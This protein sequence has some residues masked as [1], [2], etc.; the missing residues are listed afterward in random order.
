MSMFKFRNIAAFFLAFALLSG[1]ALARF[2]QPD[3]IG[4]EGGMNLYA[5]VDGNPISFSDPD[6]LQRRPGG[7]PRIR[8][9]GLLE[10]YYVPLRSEPPPPSAPV[11]R[12][13]SQMEL[14][15]GRPPQNSPAN[16]CGRDFSGHAFDR[17]QGRGLTPSVVIDAINT[18]VRFPGGEPGT[19]QYYSP[20]NNVSVVINSSTGAVVSVRQG[21]PSG[22]GG[23]R[24]E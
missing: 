10:Q 13:G 5:Y 14:P 7:G 23:A 2:V 1:G 18:G 3:P 6:G 8:P 17:M 20:V 19:T 22:L 16:V 21:V 15:P 24:N 9:G 11:G 4:L 12:S